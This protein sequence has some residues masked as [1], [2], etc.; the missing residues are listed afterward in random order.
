[1]ILAVLAVE[2]DRYINLLCR[3]VIG[4]ISLVVGVS[5]SSSLRNDRM[6]LGAHTTLTK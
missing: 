1:M 3:V 5:P 4:G 6:R 2:V